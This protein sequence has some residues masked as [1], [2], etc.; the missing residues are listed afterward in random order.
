MKNKIPNKFTEIMD[1][2]KILDKTKENKNLKNIVFFEN[3]TYRKD[4]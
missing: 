4:S 1:L 2:Q 3:E